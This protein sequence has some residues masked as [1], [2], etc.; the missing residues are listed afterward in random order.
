M[1]LQYVEVNHW[2]PLAWIAKVDSGRPE[3]KVFH[4]SRVEV[5][6]GFFCEAAWAGNFNAGEFDQTD[7]VTGSGGR[8]RGNSVVF[9]GAGSMV[10]RLHHVEMGSIGWVSNSLACLL[11]ITQAEL[12]PSYPGYYEDFFSVSKGLQ[13][14]R[15]E[16]QTS[17]GHVH[18]TYFD[19]LRWDGVGITVVPKANPR[20]D[21][22]DFFKYVDF[23]GLA[24]NMADRA[25]RFPY[26]MLGT[27][28][29]GYDSPAVA[30]LAAEAGCRDVVCFDTS[31]QGEADSGHEIA[32][33][34]GLEVIPVS[35]GA[36]RVL[37][38]PEIPFLAGNGI[39][40]ELRFRPAEPHLAGRVL[41]T[42]YLGDKMWGLD[43]HEDLSRD[44]VRTDCAGSGFTEYRLWV[45]FLHCPVPFW[46]CRQVEDVR[47]VST[48]PE[49]APWDLG[50]DYNRPIPRRILEEK[51]VP[52]ALFGVRKRNSSSFLHNHEDYLTHASIEDFLRWLKG[53]RKKWIA[54]G[55]I[56]PFR[57]QAFD[58]LM[59][60]LADTVAGWTRGRP[61]VWR[62]AAALDGRPLGIR[63]YV[64]PWAMTHAKRRYEATV[65]SSLELFDAASR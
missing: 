37:V 14:Y 22:G 39:G 18:L 5:T 40:E 23:R 20:R 64:F 13:Q 11:S 56:P 61:A 35:L 53:N 29:T 30:A 17:V 44:M 63:R 41:L 3:I 55:R 19:N 52:R 10:D 31:H 38:R 8:L 50:T 59:F 49:M 26:R 6:P 16:L 25:R 2:P 60:R 32:K 65:G 46:G 21:L 33:C 51:G 42:G 1:I 62:I 34:L 43:P 27:I 36:W 47:T 15:R 24:D 28:S 12:D 45:G 48:L 7:I 58:R 4:G 54:A 9:V 57:S